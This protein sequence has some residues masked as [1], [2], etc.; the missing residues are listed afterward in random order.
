M[1]PHRLASAL[2]VGLL[3]TALS[4][5][6]DG[7]KPTAGGQGATVVVNADVYTLDREQPWV[8]AFAY[9]ADG[10]IT[11]VGAES[12]VRAKAG[13]GAKVIDARGNMV[14]PG[15]QD[16]H[17]H[18]PEAGVNRDLCFMESGSTLAEYED[19]AADCA[20]EQPESTWVRAAGPSIFDLLDADESPIDVLDR[21]IPDRPALILDD[22]GHAVWTNSLGL[23][24]AGI[25][26]DD[27]DP[28]GGI[29]GRDPESGRLNGLLLENA[30]QRIRNAAA[31]DD[32]AVYEGLRVALDELAENG[33][34]SVS[35]AGGFWGQ[36][37]P[38]AWQRALKEGELSVRAVNSLYLYPDMDMDKQLAEFER[39]FSDDPNSLLRFN[40]AKIYVD[41]I[42]DLGTAWMLSPYKKPVN[43]QYP[44]GFPYF[45]GDQLREYV[46]E[47]HRIGYRM[48]FHVIGD[49]ATRE[50]LDAVEAIDASQ[51]EVSDRRHRTTHTYLVHPD[52][53]KRF[54]GLGVIADFQAG[55]EAIDPAYHEQISESIGDQAFDLIPTAKLLDAGARVSLSSDWDADPLSPFG[56]IERAVTRESNAVDSVE[57]AIGLATIDAAH[58]LGQDDTTGSIEVGKQADYVIV[59]QN[60]LEVPVDRVDQTKVLLTVLAGDS[61]YQAAGFD[62]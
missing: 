40:T 35:D 43:P 33:I 21:A 49:A 54:A 25:G 6:D 12:D 29:Y 59:D 20:A 4:S 55:P 14:L 17:L 9:D 13:S 10:R 16:T 45:E 51:D 28:Q 8:E 38:A 52:D 2:L 56:T 7:G 3:V 27:P 15:F 60:L 26:P 44:S 36:N 39:R 46:S 32:A 41:G 42:L 30:Q 47:L 24:A 48:H 58:A 62:R 23:E 53:T 11:A 19:M 57:T 18:V 61:T 37:H 5:C 34:T 1:R 50:A 22:L 31:P